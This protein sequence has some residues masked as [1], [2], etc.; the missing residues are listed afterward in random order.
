MIQRG[1]ISLPPCHHLNNSSNG[2]V[3]RFLYDSVVAGLIWSGFWLAIGE[4]LICGEGYQGGGVTI[5]ALMN[6]DL[7]GRIGGHARL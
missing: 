7:Y 5:G 4:M 3:V 2:G 1:G 6:L